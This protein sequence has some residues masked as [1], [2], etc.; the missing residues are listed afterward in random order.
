MYF[1][2]LGTSA[3]EQFPGLWCSC[4]TCTKA[5]ELGGRNIRSNSCAF[6]S[7][8][9]MLDFGAEVFQQARKFDV[10]IL[11]TQ[12]LFVTHSHA[13]HCGNVAP[14]LKEN[15][16]AN[17]YIHPSGSENLTDPSIA[18]AIR[19]KFYSPEMFSRFADM[20]PVP[21]SRI[22]Y[23]NDGDVFDLGDGERLKIIFAPGHQ[24]DG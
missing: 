9:C 20:E 17:V 3:G 12:Y 22:K 10:P 21:P 15:P 11:D 1:Q 16:N 4:P 2:F 6:L 14:L 18:Q 19:R 8:D 23:F 13:D 5:R 7:P 24:P